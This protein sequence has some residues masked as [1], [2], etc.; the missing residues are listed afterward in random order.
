MARNLPFNVEPDDLNVILAKLDRLHH[1]R[2]LHSLLDTLLSETRRLVKAD[3]GSI[4]L[5]EDD[6]LKF[7][8]VQNDTLFQT[9]FLS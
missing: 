9:D 1:V 6:Q 5:L 7:S 3:A 8:Y 4:F 2:D